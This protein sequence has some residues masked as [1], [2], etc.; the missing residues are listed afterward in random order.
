MRIFRDESQIVITSNN[1]FNIWSKVNEENNPYLVCP[2]SR[3]QVS[4]IVW[5]CVLFSLYSVHLVDTIL[6]FVS[7]SLM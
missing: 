5:A 2:P 7:I 1:S 4:S 6:G 3:Q